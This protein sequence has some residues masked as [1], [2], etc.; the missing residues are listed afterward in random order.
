LLII[1]NLYIPNN[2]SKLLLIIATIIMSTISVEYV[3]TIHY[4]RSF[5]DD[6]LQRQ[7]GC[8]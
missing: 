8:G 3:Y 5:R 2:M 6:L 1:I 4:V 7:V